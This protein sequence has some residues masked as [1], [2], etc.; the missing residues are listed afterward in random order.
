MNCTKVKS[1]YNLYEGKEVGL[2]TDSEEIIRI[3]AAVENI[4][5]PSDVL[6]YLE[7]NLDINRSTFFNVYAL[8]FNLNLK[9]LVCF[10][11]INN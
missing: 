7:E 8:H 5:M 1:C 3:K 6:V 11:L 10:L 9:D 2:V 4:E